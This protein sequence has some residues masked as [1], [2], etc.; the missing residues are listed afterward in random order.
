VTPEV[1]REG[2]VIFTRYWD[3]L[4]DHL[5]G[6]RTAVRVLGLASQ[7]WA[8]GEADSG[9]GVPL[10]DLETRLSQCIEALTAGCRP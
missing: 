8:A 10:S 5:P 9:S 1:I 2:H 6:D 7:D 4:D 3:M